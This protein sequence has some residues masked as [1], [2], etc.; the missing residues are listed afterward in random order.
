MILIAGVS[1]STESSGVHALRSSSGLSGPEAAETVI[2]PTPTHLRVPVGSEPS[3]LGR[4]QPPLYQ[5]LLPSCS[6][7]S[8]LHEGAPPLLAL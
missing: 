6:L 3:P 8:R 5:S 7:S 4:D 1:G 2:L